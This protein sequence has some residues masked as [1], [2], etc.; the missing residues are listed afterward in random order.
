MFKFIIKT[1][2]KNLFR[3]KL[4]TAVSIAAIAF[5][6][7]IVVFARG[8]ITGMVDSVF[9]DHIRYNSGHVKIMDKEYYPKQRLLPLNYPVNGFENTGLEEMM[10][11]LRDIDGVKMVIPRL[12]F[13]AMVSTGE[14]LITMSGWGVKPKREIE[15]TDIEVSIKKG[16]MIKSGGKEIVMGQKL[17]NKIDR[18]VGDSVTV[19]FNTSFNSLMGVTF[20]IVGNIDSGIK[21]LDEV[22]FY[23]PLKEAQRLLYMDGQ[24]TELLLVA[25]D[26][27]MTENILPAV[28]SYLEENGVSGK[29]TVLGYNESSALIPYMEIAKNIYNG[30]YI[31]LILLASIV[32]VNTMIMI[33]KERTKEVGMMSALGMEGNE[34]LQL[35]MIEGGIMGVAGSFLGATAGTLLNSYFAVNGLDLTQ[36]V[37]GFSAEHTFN[38]IIYFSASPW[39]SIFA[40]CLGVI[41][42]TLACILPARRAANLD[43]ARAIREG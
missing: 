12:K 11:G 30:I 18:E 4:R 29:Y 16:R 14:E 22:L 38:S 28:K 36:T 24:V 37:S 10:A 41:I 32:V 33:V 8:Y 15:F 39:N 9:A 1:A 27:K 23:L 19:L 6:V 20:E 35:F 31:F 5:S 43:P 3:H 42:V 2:F 40:F 34:I 17:L 13:G 25:R 21:L 26:R 7:M